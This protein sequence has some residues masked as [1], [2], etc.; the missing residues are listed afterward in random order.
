VSEVSRCPFQLCTPPFLFA[1]SPYTPSCPKTLT[2]LPILAPSR[3]RPLIWPA[4]VGWSDRTERQGLWP[5]DLTRCAG[6]S[7]QKGRIFAAAE[8][9]KK[10]QKRQCCARRSVSSCGPLLLLLFPLLR[11][12]N[13]LPCCTA[14]GDVALFAV[15]HFV[16]RGAPQRVLCFPGSVSKSRWY[17]GTPD[18]GQAARCRVHASCI[19]AEPLDPG[20]RRLL[21]TP[22]CPC[23][24]S[25][26]QCPAVPRR[27]FTLA[28]ALAPPKP[29]SNPA[30]SLKFKPPLLA[31][32]HLS[33]SSIHMIST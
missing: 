8:A 31:A 7:M 28:S 29:H 2:C 1:A 30:R 11:F 14:W 9:A 27:H 6:C 16:D 15:G 23:G 33:F 32:S 24:W 18:P 22:G 5:S 4:L 13:P 17:L 10:Q 3:P 21:H 25:P 19:L 26:P 12:P 20:Q